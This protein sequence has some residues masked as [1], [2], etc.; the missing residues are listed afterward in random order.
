[1]I[2]RKRIS[3]LPSAN[4][5]QTAAAGRDAGG[6][7]A[8]L[9]SVRIRA[10]F[11]IDV[12]GRQGIKFIIANTGSKAI[13]PYGVCIFN[14][15]CGTFFMFPSDVSGELLPEQE[16][17]HFM[18]V[19]ARGQVPPH[20]P[21]LRVNRE[22]KPLTDAEDL[23]FAF[24]MVLNHSDKVLYENKKI[25]LGFVRALRKLLDQRTFEAISYEDFVAMGSNE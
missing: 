1:M 4:G 11:Q 23:E 16:R 14:P 18:S 17:E 22:G 24:R 8:P 2:E 9:V 13:P 7:F 21:N 12:E 15:H 10:A 20:Y 25:G 3:R 6:R 19:F 5:G